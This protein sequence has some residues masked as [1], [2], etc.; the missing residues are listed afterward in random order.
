M[1]VPGGHPQGVPK[2]EVSPR[3]DDLVNSFT[4]LIAAITMF[5]WPFQRQYAYWALN[6]PAGMS[7]RPVR[8]FDFHDRT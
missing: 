5:W 8:E 3:T 4:G 7:P 2:A 1:I 6:R